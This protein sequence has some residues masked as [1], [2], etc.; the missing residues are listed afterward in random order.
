MTIQ[1]QYVLPNCSLILEGL[2]VDASNVLSI[3]ANAEFKIVGLEKP[4]AGGSEFFKALVDAVSAYCQRLLSGL[5]HPGHMDSQ[6]SLVTV[7]PEAGQ[8]H[9]LLIKPGVLDDPSDSSEKSG[10][11]TIRL[12][13]VQL[14]DMA[15]AIDQFNADAQV[16]PDF[17]VDLAPLPRKYVRA[18]EPLAQRAIPPLLG[19][20]TLAVAAV[21]LFFLPVPELVEPEDLERQTTS[22][23]EESTGNDVLP[24]NI[25]DPSTSEEIEVSTNESETEIVE[26]PTPVNAAITDTSQL[27]DLQ[28]QAEQ[29]L[30]GAVPE[31]T[32]FDQPLSYQISVAENGD[33]VGYNPLDGISL[34]NVDNTPLPALTYIPV[35]NAAV[36]PIAQFDAIFSSDGTV[37]VVSDQVVTPETVTP[38]IESP[39]GVTPEVINPEEESSDASDIT[40]Q[41]AIAEPINTATPDES[42]VKSGNT[43]SNLAAFISSPIQDVDRIYEL[44]QELRRTLINSRSAPWSGSEISYRIRLDEEGNITGYE[45]DDPAAEQYATELKISNLVKASPSD[46]PQLDFLVVINDANVIEVSPWDGWP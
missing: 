21:G 41:S 17:A 2:S 8:Y 29:Q 36:G 32:T 18:D 44:N 3:L 43:S 22:A 31:G 9:C 34:E 27:M 45:A 20:G 4:L 16:L 35:D 14:F 6:T 26:S 19:F 42:E 10:P 25:S 39:E 37:K 12:S 23:L 7:E 24:D 11:Q 40:E 15:E 13:T 1:R 46:K 5:D 33:I 28:Q 38:E 30:S